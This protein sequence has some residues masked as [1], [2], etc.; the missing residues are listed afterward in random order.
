MARMDLEKHNDDVDNDGIADRI[1]ECPDE[2]GYMDTF[3]CPDRDRDGIVDDE[4]ECPDEQALDSENGCLD[5]QPEVSDYD[6]YD[7]YNLA[8]ES[9]SDGGCSLMPN[10]QASGIL[11]SLVFALSLI[12][13]VIRRSTKS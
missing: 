5:E 9:L 6:V 10:S 7:R 11:S 1:D 8:K 3:G 4:D 13:I 12:P 2:Y